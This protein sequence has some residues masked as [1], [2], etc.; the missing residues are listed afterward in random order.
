MKITVLL[1]ATLLA[2]G[3][4]LP[5]D[6][7][8]SDAGGCPAGW[9]YINKYC[10]MAST[11][12]MSWEQAKNQCTQRGGVLAVVKSD[13]Q[14]QD[15]LKT[16]ENLG[17]F[18]YWIGIKENNGQLEFAD[19]K[20]NT[21][22]NWASDAAKPTADKKC[23]IG[24]KIAFMN[25]L[26]SWEAEDCTR[27]YPFSCQK[28]AAELGETTLTY[29]T[30]LPDTAGITMVCNIDYPTGVDAN[31]DVE[32]YANGQLVKTDRVKGPNVRES[33]LKAGHSWE[34]SENEFKAGDTLQCKVKACLGS[35]CTPT[36]TQ[37]TSND[38]FVGMRV[39]PKNYFELDECSQKSIKVK[40]VPTVPIRC[41][42]DALSNCNDFETEFGVQVNVEHDNRLKISECFADF[43]QNENPDESKVGLEIVPICDNMNGNGDTM[44]VRFKKITTT[45]PFW[46]GYQ[47]E[48]VT[49]K[50]ADNNSPIRQCYCNDDPHCRT[51]YGRNYDYHGVGKYVMYNSNRGDYEVHIQTYRCNGRA[52]C[53]CATAVRYKGVAVVMDAC[54]GWMNHYVRPAGAT[55]PKGM[56]IQRNCGGNNCRMT[57]TTPDG[58]QVRFN[59]N[60][61]W[62]QLYVNAHLESGPCKS[63]TRCGGLCTDTNGASWRIPHGQSYFEKDPKPKTPQPGGGQ[64]P[65]Q[66]CNCNV[67]PP[68]CEFNMV[69]F[70]DPL[71]EGAED[72]TKEFNGNNRRKRAVSALLR[73]YRQKTRRSTITRAEA[74]KMCGDAIFQSQVGKACLKLNKFKNRMDT[75][76]INCIFDVQASDDPTVVASSTNTLVESCMFEAVS[77]PEN[78]VNGKPP[79]DILDN[80]CENDCSGHGTCNK[81]KCTCDAGYASQDCSIKMGEA[82]VLEATK[83]DVVLCDKKTEECKTQ[84][85]Y[86]SGILN[87]NDL[88]CHSANK[89]LVGSGNSL[90]TKTSGKQ[91]SV[92]Q[93]R[94]SLPDVTTPSLLEIAISNDG[95]LKSTDSKAVVIHNSE[96]EQ[97]D[98]NTKQCQVKD[99]KCSIDGKCYDEGAKNPA[100]SEESCKPS[101]S[102]T[103]WTGKSTGEPYKFIGCFKDDIGDRK[104][105]TLVINMRGNLKWKYMSDTVKK[106]AEHVKAKNLKYFAI[107]HYGECYSDTDARALD[108][109]QADDRA[110]KKDYLQKTDNYGKEYIVGGNH[111]NCVY[112]LV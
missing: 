7:V 42:N 3:S 91:V 27:Q 45:H 85:V 21:Y 107:Q 58:N 53:T 56:H 1:L 108:Y 100:N 109:I 97:C 6:E 2:I 41:T 93:V 35:T 80:I 111:V 28:R 82:P 20:T 60:G 29:K 110:D 5:F 98:A 112:K 74:E 34:P 87:S 86:A 50:L 49:I 66:T 39:E 37:K 102:Q 48:P 40:L 30:P 78:H 63:E 33:Y 24:N 10:Y 65:E 106:C 26:A 47:P 57:V 73:T 25:P 22:R 62:H 70:F 83:L 76:K 14:G 16:Q 44:Q 36:G 90:N 72:I 68:D 101:D 61:R 79:T 103:S 46:K 71:N 92:F 13:Q 75:M 99:K 8:F 19:G 104:L 81:G 89:R 55:L 17:H 59:K 51:M 31:F 52:S 64:L 88:T 23:V 105:K 4:S 32:W 18:G 95:T 11:G 12:Q 43:A 96:C 84:I 69:D 15:V 9:A 94:C 77:N 38:Y 54:S 67:D